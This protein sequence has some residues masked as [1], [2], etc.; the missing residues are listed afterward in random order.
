MCDACGGKHKLAKKYA[1]FANVTKF[2]YPEKLNALFCGCLPK[3]FCKIGILIS[4]IAKQIY[5][6]IIF[7]RTNEKLPIK[8]RR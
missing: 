6:S 7:K 5:A 2:I 4:K 8:F 1:R 3:T